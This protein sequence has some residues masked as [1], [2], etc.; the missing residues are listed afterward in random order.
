M[1]LDDFLYFQNYAKI[2]GWTF[3]AIRTAPSERSWLAT[4]RRD[5]WVIHTATRPERDYAI[6]AAIVQTISYTMDVESDVRVRANRA[7]HRID[8]EHSSKR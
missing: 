2:R 4:V 5:P 3:D 8:L 6:F 7:L 1:M